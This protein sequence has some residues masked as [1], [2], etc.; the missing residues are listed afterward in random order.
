MGAVG[1]VFVGVASNFSLARRELRGGLYGDLTA[2]AC[3]RS[4]MSIPA[5]ALVAVLLGGC[6]VGPGT[7]QADI[8]ATLVIRDNAVTWDNPGAFGPLPAELVEMGQ[9]LC[10]SLDSPDIKFKAIGYHARAM[11][12]NGNP[13]PGGGYYCVRK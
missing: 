7:K 12:L 2:Y 3:A 10:S 4:G 5:S 8:P 6:A 11:D 1:A 9:K 13:L